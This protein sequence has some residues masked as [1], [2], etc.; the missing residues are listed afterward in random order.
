M[1]ENKKG[2]AEI[3]ACLDSAKCHEQHVLGAA[4][5]LYFIPVYG[6]ARHLPINGIEAIVAIAYNGKKSHNSNANLL[7]SPDL[8]F[9]T[10]S[11]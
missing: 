10:R 3:T 11:V 9:Y 7:V 5:K 8:V 2:S 6:F 1:G 4:K